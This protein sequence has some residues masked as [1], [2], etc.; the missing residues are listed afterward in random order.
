MAIAIKV[1]RDSDEGVVMAAEMSGLSD[2][3]GPGPGDVPVAVPLP[4]LLA[5][6]PPLHSPTEPGVNKEASPTDPRV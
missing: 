1:P 5:P 3:E 6:L 2:C 4:P